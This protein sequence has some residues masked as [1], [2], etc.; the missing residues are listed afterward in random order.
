MQNFFYAVKLELMILFF[1][2][3]RSMSCALIGNNTDL[4]ASDDAA[5]TKEESRIR[6]N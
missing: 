3:V 6:K 4:K 2:V 5:T 1:V